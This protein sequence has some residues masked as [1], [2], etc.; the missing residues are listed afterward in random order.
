MN[1]YK[2]KC[3]LFKGIQKLYPRIFTLERDDLVEAFNQ[4]NT[5][6]VIPSNYISLWYYLDK[7]EI[8]DM[9]LKPT[10]NWL[11]DTLSYYQRVIDKMIRKNNDINS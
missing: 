5:P 7:R 1:Q 6:N 3:L 9:S 10:M 4:G 8:P 11:L 2:K